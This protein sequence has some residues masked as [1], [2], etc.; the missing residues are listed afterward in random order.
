MPRGK[1]PVSRQKPLPA[2]G[3]NLSLKKVDEYIAEAEGYGNRLKRLQEV[4][5]SKEIVEVQQ[6]TETICRGIEENWQKYQK[7]KGDFLHRHKK[8]FIHSLYEEGVMQSWQE[9]SILAC[10]CKITTLKTEDIKG[11]IELF[12]LQ[13]KTYHEKSETCSFGGF[14]K[15]SLQEIKSIY[16]LQFIQYYWG[17][18]DTVR[19]L[20]FLR[21]TTKE[22]RIQHGEKI[23]FPHIVYNV[24]TFLYPDNKIPLAKEERALLDEMVFENTNLDYR[25]CLQQ[26]EQIKKILGESE[27]EIKETL[28]NYAKEIF[29]ICLQMSNKLACF[30][31]MTFYFRIILR[32]DESNAESC[33]KF[34]K[35][36]YV[37]GIKSIEESA[38]DDAKKRI[39]L[40]EIKAKM[41]GV[42]D[43]YQFYLPEGSALHQEVIALL[44]NCLQ[45]AAL[46]HG[47]LNAKVSLAHIT[48]NRKLQQE[49][50]EKGEPNSL[51]NEAIDLI[52]A[53]PAEDK[54]NKTSYE[55]ALHYLEQALL[56]NNFM[57]RI[58]LGELYIKFKEYGKAIFYLEGLVEYNLPGIWNKLAM[59]LFYQKTDGSQ[60]ARIYNLLHMAK[61]SGDKVEAIGAT[62]LLTQ[63]SLYQACSDLG[64][65]IE[66]YRKRSIIENLKDMFDESSSLR[67]LNSTLSGV[68]E[69]IKETSLDEL[70]YQSIV[71]VQKAF[72]YYIEII[73]VSKDK[74]ELPYVNFVPI[75]RELINTFQEMM[76]ALS[77]MAF[78][79]R[80]VSLS[81]YDTEDK[82]KEC[83]AIF[84]RHLFLLLEP[85]CT[86][87]NNLLLMLKIIYDLFLEAV[88]AKEIFTPLIQRKLH[89][90]I[91]EVEHNK[92][93]TR[94]NPYRGLS[95]RGMITV[96][97]FSDIMMGNNL[98]Y[99]SNIL[100]QLGIWFK[101]HA[102]D[103]DTL[104]CENREKIKNFLNHLQGVL[105][106]ATGI[107]EI[108]KALIGLGLLRIKP[109]DPMLAEIFIMITKKLIQLQDA[110]DL[111]ECISVI[112]GLSYFDL[113]E[114]QA[115]LNILLQRIMRDPQFSQISFQK[116]ATLCHALAVIE[117]NL[118]NKK[119]GTAIMAE[120]LAETYWQL[121]AILLPKII[122]PHL[123]KKQPYFSL[124]KFILALDYLK[125]ARL[126][127]V[128]EIMANPDF[129]IKFSFVQGQS[130]APAL[131]SSLQRKMVS[132]LE[133]HYSGIEEEYLFGLL[134][135]DCFLRE[136]NAL[137]EI[138]GPSHYYREKF[139]LTDSNVGY[140]LER[141]P[142]DIFHC[143][144]K[145]L[146]YFYQH[147]KVLEL[148]I[149]PY[150]MGDLDATDISNFVAIHLNKEIKA[151]SSMSSVEG[152]KGSEKGK[153]RERAVSPSRYQ[154]SY[155]F[156]EKGASSQASSSEETCALGH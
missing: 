114:Q 9:A 47:H 6:E 112:H 1:H 97:L 139:T 144:Y 49:L 57:A 156:P 145:C 58:K 134:P 87:D 116:I 108:G 151:F 127:W 34:L 27:L 98:Y 29:R 53:V 119:S 103:D 37:D 15:P 109:N 90:K 123:E 59:A 124:H 107:K 43:S 102:S 68:M 154:C 20:L 65:L 32:L 72:S 25:Q 75:D 88:K 77:M 73:S 33:F 153:E 126:N 19:T 50:A 104:I 7:W 82:I 93:P 110:L 78:N 61:N 143:R 136:Q 147:N 60:L 28:L 46:E 63:V 79:A 92:S 141:T 115:L 120:D 31:K 84:Y 11:T 64:K 44:K 130:K 140:R 152:Q 41:S 51:Y 70:F 35:K 48:D 54:L 66:F 142:L 135:G 62:A 17:K 22:F 149:I 2:A 21:E 40:G 81:E 30:Y 106:S 83:A 24:F 129:K 133:P 113:S 91:Q 128:K 80:A 155:Y 101:E 3:V 13:I 137:I 38:L 121:F 69:E 10:I 12:N 138:H 16:W 39:L 85:Y 4:F 14:K 96:L 36:H 99:L 42:C 105:H 86:Q 148:I 150:T 55:K 8:I 131:R 117:S 45:E 94:I 125:Y 76:R 111:E 52:E 74:K 23:S 132:M 18:K 89:E 122:Q 100:F 5:S 118:V 26:K 56:K 146:S 71:S 95:D 67:F